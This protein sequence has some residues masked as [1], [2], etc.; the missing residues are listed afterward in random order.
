MKKEC[1]EERT[2]FL[3]ITADNKISLGKCCLCENLLK[4]PA[5][6]LLESENIV[7]TI[8]KLMCYKKTINFDTTDKTACNGKTECIFEDF[9]LDTIKINVYGCNLNCKMCGAFRTAAP[10]N[11]S[12]YFKLLE[13]VKGNKLKRL[14]LNSHGEP[15]LKKEETFNYLKSLTK[16]DFESV[17][18]ITNG[19]LINE[20]DI[21]FL[22]SLEIKICVIVS[23]DAITKETYDK[24]RIGGDFDKVV[25]NTILLKKYGILENINV[26]IQPSNAEEV[27]LM[28]DY[29]KKYGIKVHFILVRGISEEIVQF[30]KDIKDEKILKDFFKE[31][32]REIE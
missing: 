12:L 24:I 29:W 11:F 17:L 20:E 13:K 22:S 9:N 21:K 2:A 15:F 31:H 16:D 27:P 3:S 26:V 6:L 8:N 5:N 10:G 19:M 4:I 30:N 14:I 25:N 18:I 1:E 28:E 32:G 23:N 7:G